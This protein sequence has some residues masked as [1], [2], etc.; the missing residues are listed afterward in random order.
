MGG[1][2]E[3]RY[4]AGQAA[5]AAMADLLAVLTKKKYIR[6]FLGHDCLPDR[7]VCNFIYNAFVKC[8]I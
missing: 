3:E 2:Y 7:I 4:D 6:E 1:I 5:V 8:S